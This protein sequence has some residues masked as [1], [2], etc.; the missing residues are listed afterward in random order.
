MLL[1]EWQAL[2]AEMLSDQVDLQ[3][4]RTS[5]SCWPLLLKWSRES[6]DRCRYGGA[7]F[8]HGT[9]RVGAVLYFMYSLSVPPL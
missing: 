7:L 4:Y 2:D 8:T 9:A 1:A 3:I 6:A 5:E